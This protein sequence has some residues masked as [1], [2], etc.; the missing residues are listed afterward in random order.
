[1]R[2]GDNKRNKRNV[3]WQQ[4]EGRTTERRTRRMFE[5]TKRGK[6]AR[7]YRQMKRNEKKKKG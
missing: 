2:G 1:L 3:I 5:R 6:N 7:N 4:G